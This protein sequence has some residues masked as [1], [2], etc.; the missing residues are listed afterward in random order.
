VALAGVADPESQGGGNAVSVVRAE[1]LAS[2]GAP[3]ITPAP[4]PGFAGAAALDAEGR[5][6]GLVSPRSP[7]SAGPTSAGT[8]AAL[9][10]AA[11]IKALL[12]KQGVVPATSGNPGIEAAKAAIVRIICV[13][14]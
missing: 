12:E 8:G 4:G 11:A 2:A 1:V 5:L 14:E 3:S 9:V 10:P 6:L 7:L 13:R